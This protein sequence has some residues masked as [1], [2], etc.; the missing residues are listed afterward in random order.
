MSGSNSI[1]VNVIKEKLPQLPDLS[2]KISK[3]APEAKPV[4]IFMREISEIIESFSPYSVLCWVR[5]VGMRIFMRRKDP[6]ENRIEIDVTRYKNK[7]HY[8][9]SEF[10]AGNESFETETFDGD[11]F[12]LYILFNELVLFSPDGDEYR[13]KVCSEDIVNCDFFKELTLDGTYDGGIL[14]WRTT[15]RMINALKQINIEQKILDNIYE[16]LNDKITSL[17]PLQVRFHKNAFELTDGKVSFRMEIPDKGIPLYLDSAAEF[18]TFIVNSAGLL[19][20][21]SEDFERLSKL[22][23]VSLETI[24]KM[25]EDSLKEALNKT[26]ERYAPELYNRLKS[27]KVVLDSENEEVVF[28]VPYTKEELLAR[29]KEL[30]QLIKQGV[31][32]ED[33]PSVVDER[34]KELGYEN[35]FVPIRLTPT[36]CGVS[37]QI[38]SDQKNNPIL[39]ERL[40]NQLKRIAEQH[41][42]YI[43]E[44]YSAEEE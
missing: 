18:L 9:L 2:G 35:C 3:I 41:R 7:Y 10:L 39:V 12:T 8:Y 36:W 21:E 28:A 42:Y 17:W 13:F 31:Q 40:L 44:A 16:I 1:W 37:V 32:R 15:L 23:K 26:S 5:P 29:K 34:L 30:V 38:T 24:K 14:T 20:S 11:I 33:L 27:I 4:D 43:E 19:H 22:N 25:A 6:R